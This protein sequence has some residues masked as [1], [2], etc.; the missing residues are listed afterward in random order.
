MFKLQLPLFCRSGQHKSKNHK[1]QLQKKK[2]GQMTHTSA[3]K[4]MIVSIKM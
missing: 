3:P 4:Y 2:K 1:T